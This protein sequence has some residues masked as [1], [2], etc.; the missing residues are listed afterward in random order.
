MKKLSFL[1]PI[2]LLLLNSCKTEQS[3]IEGHRIGVISNPSAEITDGNVV[4]DWSYDAWS[5]NAIHFYDNVA[6]DGT[7][8]LFIKADRF[9]TGR[10][11]TKV[12]LK[13]WST[14]RFTGWIKTE[15]LVS[16]SGKGAG[17]RMDGLECAPAGYSGTNDWQKVVYEFQTGNNDCV[18]IAC[19]LDIEREAKGRVWFDNM[20]LELLSSEKI[21]TEVKINT[22]VK[23]EA[24]PVYIYG[25]FIEHL[26]RCIYGGIWAEMLEDRKFWYTPGSRESAWK[27]S[28]E[29]SMLSMDSNDPFTGV[30]TPVLMSD[31]TKKAILSQEN[32]GLKE[33][34]EYNGRIVL[35][36]SEGI[37]KALVTLKWN[38]RSE[39]VEVSNLNDKYST[40]PLSFKSIVLVH[41][42]V[43]SVEPVGSGKLWV[44]TVS[45]MPSDNIE[46]FRIDVLTLLRELNSPVYRWPG[47]N[48]V[49]GYNWRDGIG[50]RD[51]RPPRKNP[52]WQGVEANDVGIHEFMR[53]CE[54]IKTEPY[55]AVNAGLG[56]SDE[57]M[58]EVQYTNGDE[59]TAMG[60]IRSA[61]GHA[62][63]WKVKFWSIGNEMY[64]DWQLGHMST[65]QFVAK[66]NEFADRMK[67]ADPSIKLISV[68]DV[69]DWDKMVLSNCA[70]KMDYISE[71]FYRQDWHGGGLMTHVNQI[72][73]AIKEKAVAHREYRKTIPELK[74]KD[75][76][77]CLDEWNYWYGP[78]IYGELGTRYY[79]RDAMGIAAGLNEYSK[80]SDI[81]YMA[82]YA[83]T[84]N[85]IGCIKTNTT[86]SVFDA[87]GQVLKLYR[88]KFGFIPVEISGDFRPL[89]VG[90][91][92]TAGGDTLTLSVVNPTW[93][94]VEFP[95]SI[96]GSTVTDEAEIW[97]VIAPDDM[98]TNEPGREPAVKIAGPELTQF[99][100]KLKVNPSS[101]TIFRIPLL[102]K[103]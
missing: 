68:G 27:I 29:Q 87:T 84:V 17:F 22:G 2:F 60:K 53:L 99:S 44:G 66:N 31:G 25:Q 75:I 91:T 46:G 81:I 28:G 76:R 24:M 73:D 64:G 41:D 6:H 45:L 39:V 102:T 8:S 34:L 47:G 11:S 20:N 82:N 59:N 13:P 88:H 12:L 49:S 40:Y 58:A 78:H 85:V 94:E 90:A 61:N 38:D 92:L 14:Y 9:T 86:H 43:L 30:Q 100:G 51:K 74:G 56:N 19:V 36:A 62:S 96:S 5:R 97:S 71:H 35:K 3:S 4:K 69:G 26:G 55:I 15:N 57:A 103:N 21:S 50:D 10:W 80:S 18:T 98:S 93:E 63:P 48:F 42:A 77:I 101:I 79:F 95:L 23:A 33:N 32:L 7:K 89:N 1:L 16:D 37:Q 52:A 54:L 72:P 83:Q 67:S 65:S 70:D